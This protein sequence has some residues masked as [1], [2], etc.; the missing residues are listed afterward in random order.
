MPPTSVRPAVSCTAIHIVNPLP[1]ALMHYH[2]SLIETL[3]AAGAETIE[4]KVPTAEGLSAGRKLLSAIGA[5]VSRILLVV[6]HPGKKT[7]IIAWPLFGYADAITWIPLSLV[8]RIEIILHDPQPLRRQVGHSRLARFFARITLRWFNNIH[9]LAHTELAATDIKAHLDEVHAILP[10]P[11][12]H[13]TYSR[14]GEQ[15]SGE[16]PT[17]RVLGQYKPARDLT[18]LEQIAQSNNDNKWR[19]EIIGRGWPQI[20]G[21]TVT[22]TFVD[23][24]SFTDLISTSD[25]VVIP[26]DRFYQSGVAVR[27]LESGVRIVAP[28]HEHVQLLYGDRWPGLVE[29]DERWD[30]A[31]AKV[32]AV[33]VPVLDRLQSEARHA[34]VHSWAAHLES[35]SKK[36]TTQ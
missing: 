28:K 27:A 15:G 2:R 17:I 35:Q 1:N 13:T 34:C 22:S 14:K 31:V 19:L 8:S 5:V 36:R 11:M 18:P 23:E 30:Q 4:V 26:Y 9:I 21:W 6:R 33:R 16:K 3:R 7:F 10:H 12:I 24:K 20:A 32:L 25:C 29:D